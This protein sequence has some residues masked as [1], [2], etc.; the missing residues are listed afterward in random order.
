[1]A[2]QAGLDGNSA[3]HLAALATLCKTIDD[4]TNGERQPK[5]A[6]IFKRNKSK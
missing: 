5:S 2:R 3:W 6:D 4:R 1:M